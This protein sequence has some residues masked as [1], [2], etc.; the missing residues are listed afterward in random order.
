MGQAQGT[1]ARRLKAVSG[2]P[3]ASTALTIDAHV[4]P[5]ERDR[6][7][8]VTRSRARRTAQVVQVRWR[9]IGGRWMVRSHMPDGAWFDMAYPAGPTSGLAAMRAAMSDRRYAE[10]WA[11]TQW[12][13]SHCD[14]G[15]PGTPE[16]QAIELAAQIASS[17][18]RRHH[19]PHTSAA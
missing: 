11:A 5:Y 1:P 14:L 15:R 7:F 6:L 18:A 2:A 16:R 4:C 8:A 3:G 17:R 13:L 10:V 9:D 12:L 19:E